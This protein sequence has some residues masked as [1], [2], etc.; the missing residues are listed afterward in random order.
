[1][2]LFQALFFYPAFDKFCVIARKKQLFNE[3]GYFNST[4]LYIDRQH[5]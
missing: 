2:D 4:L 3:N 1:M 5:S